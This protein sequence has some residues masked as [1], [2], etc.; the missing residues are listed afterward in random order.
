MQ[1]MNSN[2]NTL[3]GFLGII[4]R[5]KKLSTKFLTGVKYTT[6]LNEIK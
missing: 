4:D 5:K 2:L 6:I 3:I 1:I